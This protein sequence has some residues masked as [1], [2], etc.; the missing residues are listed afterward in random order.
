LFTVSKFYKHLVK[1]AVAN[2]FESLTTKYLIGINLLKGH[3]AA[4]EI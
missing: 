3:V 1:L 2:N 4:V